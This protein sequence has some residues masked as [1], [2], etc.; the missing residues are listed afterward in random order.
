MLGLLLVI[1]TTNVTALGKTCAMSKSKYTLNK[2]VYLLM[3]ISQ[4]FFH[5]EPRNHFGSPLLNQFVFLKIESHQE[6]KT[7]III[8]PLEANLNNLLKLLSNR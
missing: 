1:K 4:N 3:D 6:R 8:I 2:C 5:C 7:I